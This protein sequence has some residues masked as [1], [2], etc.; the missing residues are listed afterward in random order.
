MLKMTTRRPPLG[1]VSSEIQKQLA[2]E[3]S[4]ATDKYDP[5]IRTRK[6]PPPRIESIQSVEEFLEENKI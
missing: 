3:R 1:I 2:E 5:L 6:A 4:K